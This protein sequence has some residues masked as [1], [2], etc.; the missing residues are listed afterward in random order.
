MDV[1]RAVLDALE[2]VPEGRC[3]ACLS[4]EIGTTY[5]QQVNAASRLLERE[6]RLIRKKE[7]YQECDGCGKV[8]VVNRP[9]RS[10]AVVASSSIVSQTSSLGINDLDSLRRDIIQWLNRLNPSTSREGFSRRVTALKNSQVLPATVASL[11]LTHAAFRNELYYNPRE[12]TDGEF[13]I[14]EAL[15]KYLR[16]YLAHNS[17]QAH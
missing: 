17:L 12:L 13:H 8:R 4:L 1:R 7:L 5:P 11:M 6:G 3:D 2:D 10:H 15:H 16:S 9:T 14:L